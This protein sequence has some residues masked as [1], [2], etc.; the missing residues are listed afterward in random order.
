[1]FG[2]YFRVDNFTGKTVEKKDIKF[3]EANILY[4]IGA[5]HSYLGAVDRR[6]DS[7]VC[8]ATSLSTS[9]MMLKI[10]C[11][12]SQPSGVESRLYALPMCSL[13]FRETADGVSTDADV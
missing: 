9:L 13:C 7:D 1:M 4:N 6:A 2:R 5:L 11:T 10:Y 3:E 8:T 12:F